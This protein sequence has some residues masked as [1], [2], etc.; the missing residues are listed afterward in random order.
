MSNTNQTATAETWTRGDAAAVM[1]LAAVLYEGNE[2]RDVLL[3]LADAVI[4]G[5]RA[6]TDFLCGDGTSADIDDILQ[7]P[8]I[9]SVD[10]GVA[11]LDRRMAARGSD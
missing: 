6:I 1:R 9:A 7:D 2:A 11:E 3:A 4:K 10:D 8:D 5:D